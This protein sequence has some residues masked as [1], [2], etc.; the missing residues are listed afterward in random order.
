MER[1]VVTF[2]KAFDS[3]FMQLHKLF[4]LELNDF[5]VLFNVIFEWENEVHVKRFQLRE[6]AKKTSQ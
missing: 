4:L 5:R 6:N 1:G 3:L 2:V